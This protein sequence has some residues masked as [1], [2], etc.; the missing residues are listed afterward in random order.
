MDVSTEDLSAAKKVA[1][2]TFG[3]LSILV[4]R[5][6]RALGVSWDQNCCC[7]CCNSSRKMRK[8]VSCATK[9]GGKSYYLIAFP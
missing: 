9:Q 6:V 7:C 8:H 5:V 2:S 3:E 4:S 1:E